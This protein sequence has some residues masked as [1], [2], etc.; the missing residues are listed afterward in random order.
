MDKLLF[1]SLTLAIPLMPGLVFW[2]NKEGKFLGC[3]DNLANILG[4]KT[5][6]DIIGKS[7][8][9]LSW[10]NMV[11]IIHQCDSELLSRGET[12]ALEVNFKNNEGSEVVVL[13]NFNVIKDQYGCFTYIIGIGSD[14]TANKLEQAELQASK[15]LAKLALENILDNIPAHIFWKD[16]N[17]I[18]LGCNNLQARNMGFSSGKEMI[19]KSN[20]DVIWHEQSEEEK[21]KQAAAIT[22]ADLEVINTG[23][24]YVAEEPLFLPD[25]SIAI[26]LSRKTPLRDTNGEI[27][28]LLGIAFDITP[29]KKVEKELY[30]TR[31][32]LEGMTMVS[33]SIAHEIRTPLASLELSANSLQSSLPLLIETYEQAIASTSPAG[34]LD[35]RILRRLKDLPSL[36]KRETQGANTFIDMLLM[37]I[38]PELEGSVGESFSMVSCVNEALA[39]YPF[40]PGQNELVH[41][42]PSVSD[43]QVRGKQKLVVHVLF[44]LI[45]NALYYIADAGKGDIRIELDSRNLIFTDT[46]AGMSP[47]V[48]SRIFERFFSQTRHGAGVG[49][50][51][52]KMVMDALG[53]TITCTSQQGSYTKFILSFPMPAE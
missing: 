36:M 35:K 28:G 12:Q 33:A 24:D 51:Y 39:R 40:K 16:R 43:F 31:H 38:N 45:K 2:K 47:E 52:C 48:L 15:D 21:I 13:F 49:L 18:L 34:Q 27:V 37:N 20:Y 26:Y 4:F 5:T 41:W 25:G 10:N 9:D 32:R 3:N 8:Q 1:D 42:V 6:Q 7:D 22:K 44:N 17:C 29:L 11:E 23:I 50:T 53:G 19:G 14:Y 46:G 30:E